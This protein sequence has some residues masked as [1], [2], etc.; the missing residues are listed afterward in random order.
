MNKNVLI[1]LVLLLSVQL[2]MASD[3]PYACWDKDGISSDARLPE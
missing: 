3:L 2:V 1:L